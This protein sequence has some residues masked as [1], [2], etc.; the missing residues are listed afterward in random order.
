MNDTLSRSDA[1]DGDALDR[2]IDA[3]LRR[4]YEPPAS[5]ETLVARALPSP[6]SRWL[7]WLVI[8]ASV[9][10]TVALFLWASR[11]SS[12]RAVPRAV[13]LA[14]V[15]PAAFVESFCRLVGPLQEGVQPGFVHSPDLER[16]YRDMDACQRDSSEAACGTSDFLGERLSQIYG[17]PIEL[18]PE[19]AGRLHG[20]FGSDEWPTATI[21]TSTSEGRTTVLI[22]ERGETLAC[23]VDIQL[24]DGSDLQLIPWQVGDVV[25]TEIT[26]L[27]EPHML[28]YFQ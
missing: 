3:A 10:A 28:A 16:L 15:D 23:C 1:S 26:P 14:S 8:S 13:Q 22:A 25:F 2:R 5:L 11:P 27:P 7:P 24:P 4:H 17:Q 19:A 21:V 20:P 9:A 12:E 18:R 6:R